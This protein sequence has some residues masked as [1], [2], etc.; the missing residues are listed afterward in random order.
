MHTPAT[1]LVEIHALAARCQELA[2]AGLCQYR[3][4][5]VEPAA[6][7]FPVGESLM[8]MVY[9]A[10]ATKRTCERLGRQVGVAMAPDGSGSPGVPRGLVAEAV[11]AVFDEHEG[12]HVGPVS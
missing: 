8:A 10:Q 9:L 12:P 5:K 2:S 4:L 7:A 11:A 6:D 3:H 1:A